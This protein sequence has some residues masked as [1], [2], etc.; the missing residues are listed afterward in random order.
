MSDRR[1]SCARACRR[2]GTPPDRE[3]LQG[4]EA[5]SVQFLRTFVDA[6]LESEI[7][8]LQLELEKADLEQVLD[9]Q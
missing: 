4:I 3:A 2:L 8:L 1:V 6:L 7:V 5:G 9:P